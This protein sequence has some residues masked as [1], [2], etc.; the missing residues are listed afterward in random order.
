MLSLPNLLRAPGGPSTGS[1]KGQGTERVLVTLRWQQM[2]SNQR[3][4][5]PGAAQSHEEHASSSPLPGPCAQSHFYQLQAHQII[6]LGC[7]WVLRRWDNH[8][9]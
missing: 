5:V 7:R 2:G 9:Q 3:P 4:T 6:Q 8:V 1:A